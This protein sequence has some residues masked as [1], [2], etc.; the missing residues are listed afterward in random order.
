MIFLYPEKQTDAVASSEHVNFPAIN[1]FDCK[2][3][4]VWKAAGTTASATITVTVSSGGKYVGVFNTNAYT[5]TVVVKNGAGITQ[6]TTVIPL[7]SGS[8]SWN[9]FWH[10]YTQLNETH[11]VLITLTASVGPVYAGVVRVGAGLVLPGMEFGLKEG[12]EDYSVVHEL[13]SGSWYIRK[14]AIA[15]KF[16]GKHLIVRDNNEFYR[17]TDLYDYFG[18]QPLAML[19][20]E[21]GDDRQW[22]CF[23]RFVD[24][25]EG[26]H[27]HP[28]HNSTSYEILEAI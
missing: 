4:K 5:A 10:E 26:S 1:L 8:R 18:P 12:R 28:F 9:R 20:V 16:S 27:D 19:L 21:G 11:S 7:T 2:P 24:P 23:G 22:C 13:S 15:R 3:A 14:R 17:L 25:V 6:S